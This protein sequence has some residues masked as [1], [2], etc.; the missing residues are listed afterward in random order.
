MTALDFTGKK[1]LVSGA[2]RGIGYGVARGFAM[3]GADLTII[4]SS[5]AIHEDART[6]AA[7][8]SASVTGLVCDITDRAAVAEHVGGLGRLDVLVNN[9]G[10]ERLTPILEPGDAVEATFRR[11]IEINV[12]GTYYV[13]REAVKLMG[14]GARIVITAS[15]WGKTGAAGFTGYC[16]SKHAN[17]GFMRALADELGPRGIAVNAVCPGWV[18]TEAAMRSLGL[19][20]ARE[21]RSEDDCLADILSAQAFDGLMEPDDVASAYLFLASD[22]AANVTGQTLNVDRGEMFS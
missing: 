17:I 21:G 12:I 19:I 11:I 9:A 15:V 6:L 18:R 8:T 13:T 3:A 7:E 4:A 22:A 14:R 10:Y 20:A 2:S 1:V 5:E 16:A